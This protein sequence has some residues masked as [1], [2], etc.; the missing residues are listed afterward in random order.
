MC[1][2]YNDSL[3]VGRKVTDTRRKFISLLKI[4]VIHSMENAEIVGTSVGTG[5][6]YVNSVM[7]IHMVEKLM[8]VM[9]AIP[10]MVVPTRHAIIEVRKGIRKHFVLKRTLRKHQHGGR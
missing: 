10:T 6:K 5:L 1:P 2:R 4:V 9:R 3:G 7:G 8:A